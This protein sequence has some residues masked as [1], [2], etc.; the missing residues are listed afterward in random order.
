MISCMYFDIVK[1]IRSLMQVV[2][3]YDIM[4]R[5][6]WLYDGCIWPVKIS[7]RLIRTRKMFTRKR[8]L[9]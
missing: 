2:V 5:C 7:E 4:D 9:T 1:V 8:S 6:M 3:K